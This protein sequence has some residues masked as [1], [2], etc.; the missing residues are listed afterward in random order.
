MIRDAINGSGV[1]S[2]DVTAAT[3]SQG[4]STIKNDTL[5]G[6]SSPLTYTPGKPHLVNCWFTTQVVNGSPKLLNNGQTSCQNSTS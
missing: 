2:G 1:G 3:V 4:L 6:W 5:D